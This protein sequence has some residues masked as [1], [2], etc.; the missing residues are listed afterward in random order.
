V[1][2]G[3]GNMTPR[4]ANDGPPLIPEIPERLLQ[5][6]PAR[7]PHVRPNTDP[8]TH[9]DSDH[10]AGYVK[11]PKHD[12]PRFNGSLPTLWLDRCVAY[13]DLYNVRP[14]NWVTTASLYVEGHAALWLQ[15]YRQLHVQVNWNRFC[16]AVIEEF[17][18]DEFEDQMHKLLQLRQLGTVTEYRLQFEV[19]MYQLLALD[20]S[21]STKFFVTQF[22]LGL[23]DELRAAVRI[24][25]PTSITRATV[26]ARIQE[27]EIEA[28]RLR[29][30]PAPAGRPPPATVAAAPVHHRPPAA[31]R[32]PP[33]DFARERQLRDFRRANNLCFKC[34]EKYSR[35]HQCKKQGAQLLTIQIGEFGE[36]L[37]DEAVRALELLDDPV[38]PAAQCC[39]LSA[40]ATSGTESSTCIR[41][42]ATVGNQAMLLLL[43]SGSSHSF[44]DASF[45]A[46][47]NCPS[48]PITPV[49]VKVANGQF[50]QCDRLIPQLEWCSQ[51]QLFHT[52]MRILDLG[53]YDGV[54]GMDWL[55]AINHMNC[56]WKDKA[57]SFTH[58][59]QWITLQGI[60]SSTTPTVEQIDL[61]TLHQLEAHNDI[62]VL[63]VLEQPPGSENT[64]HGEIP[65]AVQV[66]LRD[67]DDVFAEPSGLPPP[68]Q[69]DHAITLEEGAKPPNS[70]PYR[71]SPLQ[72]DEIERQ[73]REVLKAGTT[74]H[75]MSPYAAPV[76]LVKKR[77]EVGGVA[78][79][80][81]A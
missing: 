54:L 41:L 35:D 78:L 14:Q 79:I 9:H 13:F 70:K 4:L 71:Y 59:G 73:V 21:L 5:Q 80:T 66:V 55:G 56:Q 67:F 11:P 60:P 27:E 36:L 81:G 18:P 42:Q 49:S 31:P 50:I 48:V 6:P 64:V 20:P 25:A 77:M 15:A 2:A 53:T 76:L 34:G 40:Q 17:G 38:Y 57:I 43:D 22:V 44:V 39:L 3:T 72:K 51:G 29:V 16:Q 58:M 47:L 74:V 32:V 19:Y 30:R 62:W 8:E 12:F 1:Q 24:Q 63:A 37:N 75:S 28:S 61:H 33:D 65:E 46:R 23:K 45:A 7:T 52:D 69:Y 68:R 10:A 26:F